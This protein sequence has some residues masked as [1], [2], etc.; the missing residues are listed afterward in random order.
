MGKQKIIVDGINVRID[1]DNY[2]S[3]TDIAKSANNE[4]RFTI[5]NWIQNTNTI[6]YLHEWE[7]VHNPISNRVQI[8]TVLEKATNNRYNMSPSK[9]I[10]MVE[11]IGM[12]SSSGRYGGTFAH[13]DIAIN[14]CYWLNPSF[15]IYFIKEFQRLKEQEAKQ[16]NIEWNIRRE[17]AKA[18]YPML[19]E[20]V[21][22]NLPKGK[23]KAGFYLADEADLI[24][25]LVFGMTAQQ[26]RKKYPN[27]KGNMRDNADI[28][29]L[30]LVSDLQIVDSLLLKWD[31][32]KPLRTEI[33]KKFANDLK[34]HFSESVAVQRVK[35]IQDSALK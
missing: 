16:L 27:L 11:A 29:E 19:K 13:Q 5:R 9:W 30:L 6:R 10:D 2:I 33:L 22:E 15:Q 8:H 20:A 21:I 17:L 4:P 18:H 7:E 24:N 34:R 35:E 23:K 14:F 25:E 3:L 28:E 32:D 1:Q 31:C 26:W 12:T